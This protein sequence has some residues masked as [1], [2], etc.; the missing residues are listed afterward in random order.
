MLH[1]PAGNKLVVSSPNASS[2]DRGICGVVY[3]IDVRNMVFVANSGPTP[4]HVPT[5]TQTPTIS[6]TITDT[7]TVTSTRTETPTVTPTKTQSGTPTPTPTQ[8]PT[9]TWTPSF[10]QSPTTTLTPIVIP[11]A[12]Q[13]P[14]KI[15]DL[16]GDEQ[17]DYRDLLLFS[18]QWMSDQKV[19]VESTPQSLMSL[20][21]QIRLLR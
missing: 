10:T 8:S 15:F 7:P 9:P 4:T 12:T 2:Y 5:V 20:L 1:H 16:S 11:T 21:Q 13:T 6:P 14:D 18:S 17:V 19:P 3:I